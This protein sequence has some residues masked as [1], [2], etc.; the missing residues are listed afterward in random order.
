[1][2]TDERTELAESL[3]P[4]EL[5]ELAVLG[6]GMKAELAGGEMKVEPS[7]LGEGLMSVFMLQ[8]EA[9]GTEFLTKWN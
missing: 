9:C 5:V 1:M 7:E 6:G 2:L 4:G 8:L 3:G